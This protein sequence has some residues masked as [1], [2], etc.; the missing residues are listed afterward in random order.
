ML[1][2][3]ILF[4]L[5]SASLAGFLFGINTGNIAGALPFIHEQFHTT[6][7]QNE[8]IVSS[9]IL[10]AAISA[11]LSVRLAKRYGTRRMLLAAAIGYVLG[12]LLAGMSIH[13][14]E[15]IVARIILGFSIGVASYAA[16]LYIAEIA[17]AEYRGFFVLLN[18]IT[19]TSGEALAFYSDYLLSEYK[20]WQ[21]MLYWGVYPAVLFLMCMLLLPNAPRWYVE[22]GNLFKAKHILQRFYSSVKVGEVFQEMCLIK[23]GGFIPIKH[24]FLQKKYRMP[25]M[26]GVGLGIFQQFFGINTIMYYGP[27]IFEKAGFSLTSLAIGVTLVMGILNIFTTLVT[28]LLVDRIGRRKLLLMGSFLAGASLLLVAILFSKEVSSFQSFLIVLLMMFFMIGYCM[29]VGSL[30]W[31]I[32]SEIFPLE[33]KEQ[34]ACIATSIQWLSNFI[35]SVTFLSLLN[36]FGP[37]IVFLLYSLVCFVAIGFVYYLLPETKQLSLE[38]ISGKTFSLCQEIS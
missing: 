6:T 19:I 38:E 29:S 26:I 31:L 8:Y 32:I 11:F 1:K 13:L 2:L 23:R 17:P 22:R 7:L 37:S 4:V 14:L 16:P 27:Y 33:M 9:T 36:C 3:Y 10:S 18:G 12:A 15:L 34:G 24:M 5:I 30:F 20:A 21:S 35:V 25:L 28:A